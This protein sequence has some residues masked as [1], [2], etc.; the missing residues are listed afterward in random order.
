M[1]DMYSSPEVL[2]TYFD[3]DRMPSVAYHLYHSRE[4]YRHMLEEADKELETALLRIKQLE[5]LLNL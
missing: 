4:N 3:S 1:S 2:A 5:T